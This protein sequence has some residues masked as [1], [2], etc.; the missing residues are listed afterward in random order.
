MI[1]I[2]LNTT[3]FILP[4]GAATLL[5]VKVLFQYIF[6]WDINREDNKKTR[7]TGIR[8]IMASIA[9]AQGVLL[10]IFATVLLFF[11]AHEFPEVIKILGIFLY[12]G[13]W[14][15]AGILY[16]MAKTDRSATA[17][18]K[19]NKILNNLFVITPDRR[20]SLNLKV[21]LSALLD[22]DSHKNSP[23]SNAGL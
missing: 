10:C 3:F 14:C 2:L 6:S 1:D 19:A 9:V 23:D 4:V 20:I 16:R 15:T 17:G 21:K 18:I 12:F 13:F 7:P 5:L 22:P 11:P 8:V